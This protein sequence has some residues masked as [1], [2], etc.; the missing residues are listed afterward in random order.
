MKKIIFYA[1]SVLL[2]INAAKALRSD[3]DTSPYDFAKQELRKINSANAQYVQSNEPFA[4]LVNAF[5]AN[6]RDDDKAQTAYL[7]QFDKSIA[8]LFEQIINKQYDDTSKK[9]LKET[10][11]KLSIAANN[12]NLYV[13]ETKVGSTEIDYKD[14]KKLDFIDDDNESASYYEYKGKNHLYDVSYGM[15]FN[16]S[17]MPVYNIYNRRLGSIN[18][19]VTNKWQSGDKKLR[20]E[21]A[22]LLT[23]INGSAANTGS[24]YLFPVLK[25]DFNSS[26]T[27]NSEY[28]ITYSSISGTNIYGVQPSGSDTVTLGGSLVDITNDAGVKTAAYQAVD[29]TKDDDYYFYNLPKYDEL[30]RPVLYDV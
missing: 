8:P 9:E 15:P 10:Q 12:G 20:G 21:I 4:P 18:F 2:S 11:N 27:E 17:N 14:N 5:V 25:L 19:T 23:T 3:D 28:N 16:L 6:A 1:M 29:F 30:G 24:K 13:L 26:V 22:E 7:Q